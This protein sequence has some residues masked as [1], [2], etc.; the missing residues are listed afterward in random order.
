MGD[1]GCGIGESG[2]LGAPRCSH[3][4]RATHAPHQI[5]ARFSA[6]FPVWRLWH[7]ILGA[8]RTG[9]CLG[10]GMGGE[11]L[12]GGGAAGLISLWCR[13]LCLKKA[14]NPC[15][16]TKVK[17]VLG[18][19]G[20]QVY[21]EGAICSEPWHVP[22]SKSQDS[23]FAPP[24]MRFRSHVEI[25]PKLQGCMVPESHFHRHICSV[26]IFAGRRG[27]RAHSTKSWLPK[28]PAIAYE[29]VTS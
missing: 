8:S 22:A 13:Q 23:A 19:L 20:S 5:T 11:G 15:L 27:L 2:R 17:T 4:P 1:G 26:F 28:A 3:I 16:P 25:R 14:L 24:G 18:L 21:M 6:S 10:K 9:L 7:W 29:R 12:G